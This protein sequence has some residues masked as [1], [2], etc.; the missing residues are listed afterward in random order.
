M[1][2]F[3]MMWI[4]D[5]ISKIQEISMSSFLYH[6]HDVSLFVYN[7]N[8]V[9]PNG[10]KKIDARKIIPES[11]IFKV[12]NTYAA[13]SDIF[14]YQMINKTGLPWVDADT[15]C[16]SD[17]WSFKDNIYAGYEGKIVVGGVLSLPQDS[18]AINYMI[19]KSKNFDKN[20]INWVEIGPS[21]V[22]ETFRKFRLME[23]VYSEQTFCGIHYS[24]W[25]KLWEP[26]CLEE[27]Q[28]IEKKAHSISA[29]NSMVT[30]SGQDKNNLPSGSAMQYFYRKFVQ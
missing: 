10:I 20:K 28:Q 25:K 18:A 1:A 17:K 7:K 9:V 22:N 29:Y 15:I 5:S 6:G 27:V 13:F 30:F 23:Y 26:E 16:V 12:K 2:N 11:E 21:L 4:G 14:R 3:G 8:L 19:N 24:K